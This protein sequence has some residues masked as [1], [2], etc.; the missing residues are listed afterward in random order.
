MACVSAL[1]D[2]RLLIA[3][4]GAAAAYADWSQGADD[5]LEAISARAV[6]ANT[7]VDRIGVGYWLR[8]GGNENYWTV[9]FATDA[10]L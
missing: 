7:A 4:G 8:T 2:W 10:P 9:I 6:F 3:G 1:A 5:P